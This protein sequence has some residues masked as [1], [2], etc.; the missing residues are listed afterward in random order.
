M[1]SDKHSA[2]LNARLK[3]PLP[4]RASLPLLH[5]PF[6]G[7]HRIYGNYLFPC[8][9]ATGSTVRAGHTRSLHTAPNGECLDPWHMDTLP[10][11][12]SPCSLRADRA[13]PAFPTRREVGGPA[14]VSFFNFVET[15]SGPHCVLSQLSIRLFTEV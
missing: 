9:S 11:W 1:G 4:V 8:I 14:S 13:P 12:H 10:F 2:Q 5:F 7:P 6:P 3:C 15:G